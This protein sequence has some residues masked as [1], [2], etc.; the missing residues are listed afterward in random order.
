MSHQDTVPP[1]QQQE[2]HHADVSETRVHD[3]EVVPQAKRRRFTAQYKLR[4]LEEADRCTERGQ[5]GELL[6]REGLYSSY[7]SKWREQRA[8]GQLHGLASKKRGRPAE[9]PAAAE[10]ARLRRENE[11]LRVQLEQAEVII[12]VQKKLA[13]LL[14]LTTAETQS[15]GQES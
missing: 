12:D 8:R 10:L 15:N 14:G 1:K 7:L 13:E 3:P 5:I 4:I 11:R 6:R 2:Q 9:A